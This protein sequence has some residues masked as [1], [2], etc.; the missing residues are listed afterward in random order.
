MIISQ[1]ESFVQELYKSLAINIPP[2][3]CLLVHDL[4]GLL[5]ICCSFEIGVN[6]R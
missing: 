1:T 6:Q 4:M 5:E 2:F 3:N